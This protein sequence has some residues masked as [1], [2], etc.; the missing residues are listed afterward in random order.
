MR[1]RPLHIQK[2]SAGVKDSCQKRR[3]L[4][5]VGG[6]LRSTSQENAR[7][8]PTDV[9]ADALLACMV[10]CDNDSKQW[11]L[12]LWMGHSCASASLQLQQWEQ[13]GRRTC[14]C[15]SSRLRSPRSWTQRSSLPVTRMPCCRRGEG[16]VPRLGSWRSGR[17]ART[18]IRLQ[19]SPTCD[20]AAR[21]VSLH[22]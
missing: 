9:A 1:V 11:R 19:V 8:G 5:G 22:V 20:R 3:S 6:G 21:Q 4:Q 15:S 10:A 16:G 2:K 7:L 12:K 14:R 17:P 13:A 18:P